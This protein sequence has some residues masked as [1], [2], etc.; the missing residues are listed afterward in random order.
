VDAG[1]IDIDPI[2]FLGMKMDAAITEGNMIVDEFRLCLFFFLLWFNLF[3]DNGF[4]AI[5]GGEKLIQGDAI[6]FG[7]TDKVIRVRARFR[8]LPLGYRLT[9]EAKFIR[10]LFL[11]KAHLFPHLHE[12][13]CNFDVHVFILLFRMAK[14]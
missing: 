10:E 8:T 4:F 5:F 6:E 14:S 11:A 3:L 1:A 12:S 7:K 9:R 13:V 2:P